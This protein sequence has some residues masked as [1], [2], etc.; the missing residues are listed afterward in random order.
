M[1]VNVAGEGRTFSSLVQSWEVASGPV[2]YPTLS[3][4]ATLINSGP[5]A[6]SRKIGGRLV[7]KKGGGSTGVGGVREGNGDEMAKAH[8]LHA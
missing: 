8:Y 6:E 3:T 7:G 1:L 5:R 4:Q 2:N